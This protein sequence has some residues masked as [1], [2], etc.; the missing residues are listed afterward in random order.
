MSG[1]TQSQCAPSTVSTS[2][3]TIVHLNGPTLCAYPFFSQ[4]HQHHRTPHPTSIPSTTTQ[5]RHQTHTVMAA[6]ACGA[7]PQPA[8]I[9]T[10]ELLATHRLRHPLLVEWSEL[11]P[12][13]AMT[14]VVCL[15]PIPGKRAALDAHMQLMHYG[16]LVNYVARTGDDDDPVKSLMVSQSL[17][18]KET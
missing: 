2:S 17:A 4:Y 14:C 12:I 16:P 5:H 11:L 8:Y 9:Q 7:Q 10:V 13:G 1:R 18:P 3:T 6:N 15:Q